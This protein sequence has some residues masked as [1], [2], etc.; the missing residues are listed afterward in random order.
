MIVP[1]RSISVP[2]RSWNMSVSERSMNRIASSRSRYVHG[3]VAMFTLQKRKNENFFLILNTYA[4]KD[5]LQHIVLIPNNT[6]YL[7]Q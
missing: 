2:E 1:E 5:Y 3:L 4:I 7:V 6:Y